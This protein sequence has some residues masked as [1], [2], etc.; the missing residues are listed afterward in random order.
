MSKVYFIPVVDG[1][2]NRLSQVAKTL[3]E[4]VIAEEEIALEKTIPMKVHFGEKGNKTFIPS[5]CFEGMIEYLKD[6]GIDSAYIETN[7]LYRGQR[8]TKENHIALAKE[9]GFTQLPIII[10][11]GERGEAYDDIK[12]DKDY[13]ETCKIGKAFSDYDQFLVMSHFKGHIAAGFGGAMKQLAM[14]FAARGGKM[15]QHSGIKPTVKA[16]Q[17]ISCGKCVEKCDVG[18]IE[19]KEK[20]AID[21]DICIGCAGCIAVCPVGAIKHDWKGEFF[22]KKLAEYAYAAQFGKKNIYIQF[23][24]NITEECDCMGHAMKT[25][26]GD[27]GVFAST[28]PVAIDAVCLDLLQ[29]KMGDRVFDNGRETIEHG[30]HIGL[31]SD[32]YELVRV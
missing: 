29:E 11:D 2:V 5:V 26:T 12:I 13:F 27:I 10:A 6:K 23:L 24:T 32:T 3:L 21:H 14:G 30:V 16:S 18:A 31:G 22:M 7:V 19:I 8:T 20:A 1:N 9:H 17:C 4:T 28:D 25:I 15:A